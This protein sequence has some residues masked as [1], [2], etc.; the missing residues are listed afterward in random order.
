MANSIVGFVNAFIHKEGL[1]HFHQFFP[2]RI[3]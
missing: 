1:K 2:D 3:F